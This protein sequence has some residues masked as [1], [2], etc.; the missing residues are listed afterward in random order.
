MCS[1]RLFD[2]EIVISDCD[3]RLEKNNTQKHGD[4]CGQEDAASLFYK[5]VLYYGWFLLLCPKGVE[6]GFVENGA[7]RCYF[8]ERSLRALTCSKDF[9]TCASCC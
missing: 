9:S 8:L 7:K 2:L 5:S 1:E 3:L 6:R 4:F